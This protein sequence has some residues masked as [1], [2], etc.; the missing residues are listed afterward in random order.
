M[1]DQ[2]F[3]LNP[4]ASFDAEIARIADEHDADVTFRLVERGDRPMGYSNVPDCWLHHEQRLGQRPLPPEVAAKA[5]AYRQAHPDTARENPRIKATHTVTFERGDQSI[6]LPMCREHA[7]AAKNRDIETF[8]SQGDAKRLPK[9]LSPIENRQVEINEPRRIPITENNIGLK[10]PS[11]DGVT[12][13]PASSR[14]RSSD[15]RHS[16]I[17][18]AIHSG[19]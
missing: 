3:R 5:E 16:F 1:A 11:H 9:T 12:W 7:D 18:D 17:S 4:S 2:P 6:D 15:S 19:S 8:K 14:V 13:L 10:P